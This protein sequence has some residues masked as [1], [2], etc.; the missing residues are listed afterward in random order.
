MMAPR[1]H[2][3]HRSSSRRREDL[4]DQHFNVRTYLYAGFIATFCFLL[5]REFGM[6]GKTNTRDHV[7]DAVMADSSSNIY[8][9]KSELMERLTKRD[10]SIDHGTRPIMYTFFE[11]IHP[12]ERELG[13]PDEASESF[14]N[15]WKA[16]WKAAGWEPIVLTLEN[17]KKHPQF[18]EFHSRVA[19]LPM[20][21][22]NGIPSALTQLTYLRWL[23]V[24]SVGGGFMCD[25]DVFPLSQAPKT[26][27]LPY[28]GKFSVYCKLYNPTN[29]GVPCLMSGDANEWT[30]VAMALL[31]NGEA[32]ADVRK[33]WTDMLAMIDL[34]LS[35]T[36]TLYDRVFQG[37]EMPTPIASEDGCIQLEA[38]NAIRF[39]LSRFP[40]KAALK[41]RPAMIRHFLSSW[42]NI[43]TPAV[44]LRTKPEGGWEAKK[45]LLP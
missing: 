22:V 7:I 39:P 8:L 18:D 1:Y 2:W 41:D 5:F 34:R 28:Q 21:K 11:W 42:G 33:G 29:T 32:N 6:M 19:A 26:S 16:A 31:E 13:I 4:S 14:I 12:R 9:Q 30:R 27:E 25:Y 43:C 10:D 37:Q 38:K 40:P 3:K 17:A 23:A 44:Q 24:A 20:P 15:E 45:N 36:Y 35:G